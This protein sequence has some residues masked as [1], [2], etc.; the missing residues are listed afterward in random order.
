MQVKKARKALEHIR[1]YPENHYQGAWIDFD[2]DG[3]Y[4]YPDEGIKCAK[5]NG[6]HPPCGTTLCLAGWVSFLEAPKGTVFDAV[7]PIFKLPNGTPTRMDDYAREKLGLT[8]SQANVLFA[9]TRSVEGL[10]AC[11]DC[12][13]KHPHATSDELFNELAKINERCPDE[14]ED[15][16]EVF[17]DEED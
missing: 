5:S 17:G 3:D 9:G 12:I 13:A 10:E 2:Y 15:A 11:I 1:K 14:I 16:E 7:S 6:D 8:W 4:K